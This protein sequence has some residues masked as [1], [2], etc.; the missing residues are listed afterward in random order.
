MAIKLGI[1]APDTLIRDAVHVAVVSF[2]VLNYGL[3][4]GQKVGLNSFGHISP[5]TS[6][7]IG[8]IDP[9][10]EESPKKYSYIWVCMFPETTQVMRHTWDHMELDKKDL[11]DY[12]YRD[13]AETKVRE[14]VESA[15]GRLYDQD[16]GC[17]GC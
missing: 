11:V 6:K 8:I 1:P 14:V 9:F 3:K 10:L 2:K 16:D 4:P 5:H 13:Y 17:R 12:T 15:A 7:F